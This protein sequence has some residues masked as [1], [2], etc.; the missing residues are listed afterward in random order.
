MSSINIQL[1]LVEH[2][3]HH[4]WTEE[5]EYYDGKFWI[6]EIEVTPYMLCQLLEYRDQYEFLSF[7]EVVRLKTDFI[8]EIRTIMWLH[9][10][11]TE[12]QPHD[13]PWMRGLVKFQGKF[14]YVGEEDALVFTEIGNSFSIELVSRASWIFSMSTFWIGMCVKPESGKEY[15]Q[16]KWSTKIGHVKKMRAKCEAKI[17]SLEFHDDW[18]KKAKAKKVLT[19]KL[20]NLQKDF[21]YKAE[22]GIEPKLVVE[23]LEKLGG[24]FLAN[25][26]DKPIFKSIAALLLVMRGSVSCTIYEILSSLVIEAKPIEASLAEFVTWMKSLV[27][28]VDKFKSNRFAKPF[29]RLL[30]KLG[31]LFICPDLK[32]KISKI[33]DSDSL[34]G[35]VLDFFSDEFHPLES[36]IHLVTYLSNAVDVF[37]KTGEFTGFIETQSMDDILIAELREMRDAFNLF[38]TGD[39]EFVKTYRIYEFVARLK[40]LKQKLTH[41][42]KSR[43]ALDLK[44]I[45]NWIREVDSMDREVTVHNIHHSAKMQGYYLSLSSGSGISKGHLMNLIANTV[46]SANGIPHAPEYHYLLNQ[47]NKFQSGWSNATTI[48]KV[49]D[50]AAMMTTVE[51]VLC[52]AD[53]LLRGSNNVPHELLGADISEK[54]SLYNQA[55]IEIWTSNSF[56]MFFEEEARF[57]SAL[58]RRFQNKIVATVRPEYTKSVVSDGGEVSSQIDYDKMPEEM[59]ESLAPDAWEFT[60]YKCQIFDSPIPVKTQL[61]AAVKERDNDYKFVVAEW[62]GKALS[63]I[64][65]STLLEYLI[66]DSKRHFEQQQRV[67]QMSEK[68]YDSKNYCEHGRPK[69]VKCPHCVEVVKKPVP[70]TIDTLRKRVVD[71]NERMELHKKVFGKNR[72]DFHNTRDKDKYE[73]IQAGYDHVHGVP[74]REFEKAKLYKAIVSYK[75]GVYK[76][77]RECDTNVVRTM[78]FGELLLPECFLVAE[79]SGFESMR[80][81]YMRTVLDDVNFRLLDTQ[82][83]WKEASNVMDMLLRVR[84][85]LLNTL[86]SWFDTAVLDVIMII[87]DKV[88]TYVEQLMADPW[89]NI[90]AFA[91]GTA[92][93]AYI[94]AKRP[95]V[96]ATALIDWVD[97][98]SQVFK[99][100]TENPYAISSIKPTYKLTKKV[101]EQYL[102][103]PTRIQ[104]SIEASKRP[105]SLQ[106]FLFNCGMMISNEEKARKESDPDVMRDTFVPAI[107]GCVA[108][109]SFIPEFCKNFSTLYTEAEV[110]YMVSVDEIKQLDKEEANNWYSAKAEIMKQEVTVSKNIKFT[111]LENLVN[112][113]TLYVSDIKASTFTSG[114]SPKNQF[115]LLPGH[116]VKESMNN[117]LEVTKVPYSTSPGNA[118]FKFCLM[119]KNVYKLPGDMVLVYVEQHMDHM[120]TKDLVQWFPEKPPQDVDVG[121]LLYKDRNG[122]VQMLDA[123]S[124]TYHEELNNE[125]VMWNKPKNPFKGHR[126]VA[127]T[128]SGLC[129]TPLVDHT[130]KK[131]CI[132]G[133]HVGGRQVDSTGVSCFVSRESLNK[134]IMNWNSQ[135]VVQENGITLQSYGK[136]LYKPEVYWKNPVFDTVDRID[137]VEILGTTEHRVTRKSK[138]VYTPIYEDVKAS[139]NL[140]VDWG[141]P[142]FTY[143]GD[144]R[145]GARSLYKTLA[146]KETLKHPLLL[147]KAVNDYT[148]RVKDALDK[149]KEFWTTDLAILNEKEIVNGKNVRY[150]SNM[151]MSSKFDAHL[152]GPKSNHAKLVDGQWEFEQ[153]VWDEF[154]KRENMMK[155]GVLTYELLV[156]ALKNEATKTTAVEVGKVRN[157]FMCGTPFQ[158]IL[159]KWLQTTCRFF[160][161]TTIFTECTVGINPHSTAWDKLFKEVMVFKKFIALDFKNFDLTTLREVLSEAIDIIFLPRRY[162]CECSEEELNVHKCIKHSIMNAICDINGD[163]MVLKAI[164]P[165]GINL[166]SILGCIVNSLNF[167]MA[168]FFLKISD[169][170]F[171]TNCILRTFGDDSFGSSNHSRWSVKNVLYAFGELGIKATDMHKNTVSKVKFYNID[172]IEFLK[173]KGRF[174]S[175]F[176]CRVAPLVDSSR[177]KMLCCHVPTKHMSIEAVTGQCVDN[178]LLESMFHGKKTYN[179]EI[180]IINEIVKKYDL[181]RFCLTLELTFEDRL[182]DW[183]SKYMEDVLD[184]NLRNTNSFSMAR[185]AN[186]FIWNSKNWFEWT[187]EFKNLNTCNSVS[188]V[189][190]VD[191]RPLEVTNQYLSVLNKV[192]LEELEY[193]GYEVESGVQKE[194]VLTFVEPTEEEVV[195]IGGS[196]P[197]VRTHGGDCSL[198]QFLAR[199]VKIAEYAWGTAQFSQQIDPWNLLWNNKRISNRISNHKLFRGKCHV[200]VIVNGN[201]FYYGKLML[202]YLPFEQVDVRSHF[203]PL[204]ALNR[205]PMSQCPHVFLDATTSKSCTMVLPF[206]YPMDYVSLQDS[207]ANRSLGSIGFYEI[208][209][210]QHANQNIAVTLNN[211]TVSVYAWFE[212]VELVGPTHLNIQGIVP[213]SGT[214]CEETSKPVSQTCT[215]V[216]SAAR[217]LAEVPVIGPYALAIEQ[218]ANMTAT[219]ASA[220]GYSN[221]LDCV[222]PNR[223]QPRMMGNICVANTT[224]SAMKLSLD[225]KQE[226]TID[227]TTVGLGSKDEL[228]IQH[229]ASKESFINTFTWDTSQ[230]VNTLLYNYRV[231]PMMYNTMGLG[232]TNYMTAVC[233]ATV[234]FS[235]WN[236]SLVFK[237]QVICSANHKGRLAIVYDPNY[238]VAGASLESNVAYM[239]IVDISQ[240]RDF[241]ITLHNHQ[242]Q[243]WLKIPAS[244]YG[245]VPAPHSAARFNTFDPGTNGTLSL[246]VLNELTSP[247]SDPTIGDTITIAS[248]IKAGNDYQVA[249]PS[250]KMAA[251]QAYLPQSGISETTESNINVDHKMQMK[252]R[253]M[254]VYQGEQIE[255]FRSLL[256]RYQNYTRVSRI[257]AI[258]TA[259]N[260]W[261]ID[262][263][264]F[265]ALPAVANGIPYAG[266]NQV[267]FTYLQYLM[268]AF[269]G[270][271]GGVRW[272]T[273]LDLPSTSFMLARR[274]TD[275]VSAYVNAVDLSTSGS[276]KASEFALLGNEAATFG[277]VWSNSSIN[278]SLEIELPFYSQYKFVAGKPTVITQSFLTAYTQQFR[279]LTQKFDDADTQD[280]SHSLLV[281]A[282]EDF[283]CYFFTGFP[284]IDCYLVAAS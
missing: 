167:R 35:K 168:Y 237:F 214:E 209:G 54:G 98:Q 30:C 247:A 85:S 231:T 86:Q 211:L 189:E 255:S 62:E 45:D 117:V 7:G 161:L 5:M 187:Q 52:L 148:A 201:G 166:T 147:E 183:K 57:P 179:K 284:P 257:G 153:Y 28:D 22:S 146:Q 76:V 20:R 104:Q 155:R 217:H 92:I 154:H 188:R 72:C 184:T 33:F 271:K 196:V 282:G 213:Q 222:E 260:A 9:L 61:G 96:I 131:S 123:T 279:I 272:K 88:M 274:D 149:D 180:K 44:E 81:R 227:P 51:G 74:I 64:N 6:N 78:L 238:S 29:L 87:I 122:E 239:E 267:A 216:A 129:G 268:G 159:R 269:A 70:R 198:Q 10:V 232:I 163:L 34:I 258:E 2:C 165:S 275:T 1:D 135:C 144:K 109:T 228:S 265:P 89:K 137:N 169:K 26:F 40:T 276:T 262:H 283:T 91:E 145:H 173:R 24:L 210:L 106:K 119:E 102:A 243:Q 140:K 99:Q 215:A 95:I 16:S 133:F 281:A 73:F 15:A 32:N 172:D 21:G 130:H 199:P 150:V 263:Q 138:V 280:H 53:W 177:F 170:P 171:H 248:Y 220:L 202:A 200:K 136:E 103:T 75:C 66:S 195:T 67:L 181:K 39:I 46:A 162:L 266:S 156:N 205:T 206:F 142:N 225:I 236:G 185:L 253:Q 43:K 80:V 115:V 249:N 42:R 18:R 203:S 83:T 132:L 116:F 190:D 245:T 121:R 47:A 77:T 224:D 27:V 12:L 112:K 208:A 23:A 134:G 90:P 246:Y 69:G 256:K 36:I 158:M 241:E 58:H 128:F 110:G 143:D 204:V 223:Y 151:N 124:I 157:F 191:A 93:G 261:Y 250:G 41:L 97:Y 176:G 240:N 49:D 120:R 59:R 277:G 118:K 111:E 56:S 186:S 113:N 114:F 218:A 11:A 207:D 193:A 65:I 251:Y 37:V 192:E 71:R 229:I 94:H 278:P 31:T 141:A 13:S 19:D 178:F 82:S 270:W 226:T 152:P 254:R 14:I 139:F 175:D 107:M 230:T 63:K 79:E 273:I 84:K 105:I 233:G 125:N 212:D 48:V 174:D 25:Y 244:W 252:D 234:P 108:I 4:Y 38:K 55:L 127:K 235:Y 160:C 219:V 60:V 264:G 259:Y 194:E 68:L 8:D 197:E 164:I 242:P 3:T 126:Y 100:W 182:K 17:K 50:A 101:Y 221:P